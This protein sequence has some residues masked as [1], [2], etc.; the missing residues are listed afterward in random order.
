MPKTPQTPADVL[1]ALMSEYQLNPSSLSARIALSTSAVRQIAIG[2]SGITAS[3]ALRLA[4]FFGH[5]PSF[6]MDLQTQS[7][8]HIAAS[9]KDLQEVLKSVSKAA[10]PPASVKGTA[11]VKLGKKPTLADKRKDAA[12]APGSRAS[13]RKLASKK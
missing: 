6:W 4:K 13:S 10:K 11:K 12:K 1:N 5:K 3:T 2:K 7:D 9:D 8:L